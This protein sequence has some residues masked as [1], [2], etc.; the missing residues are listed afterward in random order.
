[1]WIVINAIWATTDG[2]HGHF[3]VPAGVVQKVSPDQRV[4]AIIIALCFV[5][6]M[7]ALAA[8]DTPAYHGRDVDG[9]G[10]ADQ[11]RRGGADREYGSGRLR[12]LRDL[13]S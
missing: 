7:E 3:D 8:F 4:E 6:P 11:G 2:G 12:A 5:A 1:M 9:D 13:P 10:F